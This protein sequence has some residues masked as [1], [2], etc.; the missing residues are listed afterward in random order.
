MTLLQVNNLDVHYGLG[1]GLNDVSLTI[2][3][4]SVLAILGR[5]GAGKSSLL[6][7]IAG[8]VPPYKGQIIWQGLDITRL[9]IHARV[10]AGISLVPE[11][12]RIFP[13]LTVKEN[14]RLG[15]FSLGSKQFPEAY[16]KVI[17]LF[18]ILAE[19]AEF[20]AGVLSG[21]EQQMLAI[22]RALMSKTR[23]LLLDEPSL[24]LSP[25][26]IESVYSQL[27]LLRNQGFTMILVEQ[28]VNRVLNIADEA[29]V[30]RNGTLV[31]KESAQLIQKNSQ[32]LNAYMEHLSP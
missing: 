32:L 21:G 2:E 18:P 19:R 16:Q 17:D 22:G 23:L 14:L 30:L 29:I 4:G 9:P 1:V 10:K 24:G 13:H 6:Q 15:G 5:N 11:G 27:Q 7:A 8:S 20:P 12:R 26:V 28:H 3:Q 25:I 31:L